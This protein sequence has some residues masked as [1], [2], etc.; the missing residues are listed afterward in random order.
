MRILVTEM[1]G[2][3]SVEL[4]GRELGVDLA[5]R[6]EARRPRRR[7]RQGAG[8]RRLVL[9][10]RRRLVRAA[11]ARRAAA[12]DRT[13]GAASPFELESL[14][15]HRREQPATGTVRRRRRSRCTSA[16]SGSSPPREGNGPVNA[17][18]NAL[19]RRVA[20][21]LPELDRASSSS[22]TRCASCA[23]RPAPTRSPGCW[24]RRRAA[25]AGSGR[26]S[27]CTPTSS[28]PPGRRWSTRSSTHCGRQDVPAPTATRRAA[29]VATTAGADRDAG[30][31]ACGWPGSRTPT[32]S[33]SSSMGDPG[34]PAD[35]ARDGAG[36]R[37]PPVRHA[38]PSPG[39]V[40][41]AGRHPAA[42]ADPAV[43][44]WSRSA[45]TTPITPRSWATSCRPRR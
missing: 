16:A 15:G 7:R 42:G 13:R 4:K 38:R 35:A 11:D 8:G 22:T 17:L 10:G 41:A 2:R 40:L 1:A 14:P 20:E 27:A 32:G 34:R 19:R 21:H 24:S 23:G 45:G 6:P 28:R 25:A 5:G 29:P 30:G 12:D 37:G 9:R 36:D 44:R 43:A 18:D 3:A 26:R 33:P 31:D 39:A